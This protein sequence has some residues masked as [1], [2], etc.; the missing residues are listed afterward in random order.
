MNTPVTS[1]VFLLGKRMTKTDFRQTKE[2]EGSNSFCKAAV[3][4]NVVC[5]SNLIILVVFLY[6]DED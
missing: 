3:L 5:F 4:I 2:L 6:Q 1:A